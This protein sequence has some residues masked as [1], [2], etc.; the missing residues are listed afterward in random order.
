MNML[1]KRFRPI[2]PLIC[3]GTLEPY[4]HRA[5]FQN[6]HDGF[7]TH[8]R[9]TCRTNNFP[10]FEKPHISNDGFLSMLGGNVCP[11]CSPLSFKIDM[12]AQHVCRTCLAWNCALYRTCWSLSSTANICWLKMFTQRDWLKFAP[13]QK[14]VLPKMYWC[15]KKLT[16]MFNQHVKNIFIKMFNMFGWNNFMPKMFPQHV[17]RTSWC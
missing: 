16:N 14:H 12:F 4:L 6:Q 10:M 15:W 9:Q 13:Q 5:H 8:V 17:W 2:F 3:R 1:T 7:G 11:T